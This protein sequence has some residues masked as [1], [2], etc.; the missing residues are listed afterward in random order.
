V[1]NEAHVINFVVVF[2]FSF[3]CVCAWEG[4][5]ESELDHRRGIERSTIFT[6]VLATKI[7]F[8]QFYELSPHVLSSKLASRK[9]EG[10][11]NVTSRHRM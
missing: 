5:E 9:I 8:L 3:G 11:A 2:D 10:V 4:I 1:T 7:G 6:S